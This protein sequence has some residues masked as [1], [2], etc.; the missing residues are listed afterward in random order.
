MSL[1]FLQSGRVPRVLNCEAFDP[2]LL[3]FGVQNQILNRGVILRRTSGSILL[4]ASVIASRSNQEFI[5]FL[6]VVDATTL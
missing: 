3:C 5:I 1:L 2:A 4:R 6:I